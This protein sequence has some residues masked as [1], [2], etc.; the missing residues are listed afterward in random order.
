VRTAYPGGNWQ[1]SGWDSNLGSLDCE[2][3]AL[4][5]MS[6][7]INMAKIAGIITKSMEA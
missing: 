2:F 5:T 3:S 4:S 7:Q 6:N 1:C